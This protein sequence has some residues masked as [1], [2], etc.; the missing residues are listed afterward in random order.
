M[1]GIIEYDG[2]PVAKG[3]AITAI[4]LTITFVPYKLYYNK[5]HVQVQCVKKKNL[6]CSLML[7]C[8]AY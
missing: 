4:A 2:S 3:T 1:Y 6:H 8:L 7:S 5:I